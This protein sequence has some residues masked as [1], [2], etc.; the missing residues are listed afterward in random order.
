MGVVRNIPIFNMIGPSGQN[1]DGLSGQTAGWLVGTSSNRT[2]KSNNNAGTGLG[3]F[4]NQGETWYGILGTSVASSGNPP[5]RTYNWHDNPVS[6]YNWGYPS[7]FAWDCYVPVGGAAHDPATNYPSEMALEYAG[8]CPGTIGGIDKH[9][10]VPM[11]TNKMQYMFVR[12]KFQADCTGTVTVWIQN[13]STSLADGPILNLTNVRTLNNT[14][15]TFPGVQFWQGLYISSGFNSGAS[16]NV[17][18]ML[19]MW[20]QSWQAAWDDDPTLAYTITGTQAAGHETT[21][22]ANGSVSTANIPVPNDIA[23]ALSDPP[24]GGGGGGGGGGTGQVTVPN[25]GTRLHYN[26]TGNTR[27]ITLSNGVNLLVVRHVNR[28]NTDV[29]TGMTYNGVALT[30][31]TSAVDS[32][33][34]GYATI[35]YLKAPPTGSAYNLV[36][37]LDGSAHRCDYDYLGMAGVNQTTPFGTSVKTGFR[38]TS[39][40][41]TVSSG[42]GEVVIDLLYFFQDT[43]P[44]PAVASGQTQDSNGADTTSVNDPFMA[45]A[46]VAGQSSTT[47][48]WRWVGSGL[49]YFAH[50]VVPVKAA[51]GPITGAT[52]AGVGGASRV[53]RRANTAGGIVGSPIGKK[54]I[55]SVRA[56]KSLGAIAPGIARVVGTAANLT[57]TVGAISPAVGG[58]TKNI[59]K[60]V[61]AIAANSHGGFD[62]IAVIPGPLFPVVP[63][64][65]PF[66]DIERDFIDNE[67]PGLFP[68][69]QTSY[70]GQI[71]KVQTDLL[72]DLAD[73]MAQWYRNLD[74][75]T[76]DESDISEW[77]FI[78]GLPVAPAGKSLEERR[79][80]V[81][82]RRARGPLTRARRRAIVESFISSV[83]GPP[84]QLFPGGLA[85]SAGGLQ[86]FAEPGAVTTKYEI[87][88]DIPN[89][90]YTVSVL[91]SAGIDEAGLTRELTRA[92]PAGIDFDVDLVSSLP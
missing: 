78:E 20:G 49:H 71:R 34:T 60:T 85:L 24:S 12:V 19:A 36:V 21:I 92:T 5:S 87:V 15:N 77:E 46:H 1:N 9:W 27:S 88:E 28:D 81:I 31:L 33:S 59:V 66:T 7:P 29:V 38:S 76:V 13:D 23:S 67:P 42:T 37:T 74:P 68:I 25:I 54:P 41:L 17:N 55:K 72:Q 35:W 8:G 16:I 50:I 3:S 22:T 75:N 63:P 64:V 6:G 47:D 14:N 70:W 82:S 86:L 61:G 58:N 39:S 57:K 43:P 26:S 10:S 40:L 83:V 91:T 84:L 69:D 18:H 4:F 52:S 89:Y 45:S 30:K 32:G 73:Q 80:A 65:A 62:P 53:V 48:E 44:V 90:T 51:V 79:A 56:I 2:R 11:P